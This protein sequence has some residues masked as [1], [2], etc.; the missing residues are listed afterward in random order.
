MK[1]KLATKPNRRGFGT[2]EI[3]IALALMIVVIV[4]AV[5]ANIS[6]QYWSMTSE[7]SNE[8]LYKA[9]TIIEQL[10]ATASKD[11]Q[12]ASSSPLT[13][14]MNPLDGAD[15]ACI[16]GGM[17]YSIKRTVFDISSCS[18]FTEAYV[19]WR[20]GMR[21]PT[22]TESLYTNLTNNNEIIA[23]G[24]DC[25]LNE[26]EGDW[27]S[28]S[29]DT[30]GSLS[31]TPL[32]AYISGIDVLQ[33]RIYLVSS[34]SPQLRVFAVPNTAPGNPSLLG[35][36]GGTGR[37]L[38][39]VDAIR[40]MSTGRTYAFVTQNA[41]TSQLA[42]FDVTDSSLPSFVSERTLSG[43][44]KT[45]DH[46]EGWRL[47]SYG[48]RFFEGGAYKYEQRLY[49][50]T[51][52]TTG[53]ELHIFNI[54]A[55]TQPTEIVSAATSLNRTVNDM[56]VREQMYN[57]TLHRYLFLAEDPGASPYTKHLRV[58]DVTDDSPVEV[59][60]ADL[61]GTADGLS[62]FLTGNRLYLGRESGSGPELYVFDV[63]VLLGGGLI[64]PLA[65]S[66]VGADVTT[67]RGTGSFLYLGTRKSGEEF[68]VWHADASTWSDSVPNAGRISFQDIPRLA[69]LGL[70]VN[71]NWVYAV[72]QSAS[73]SELL[74]VINAP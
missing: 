54:N 58:Y 40:D 21:Y 14:S 49:V 34:T 36:T 45:G 5:N 16:A 64:T 53:P 47:F 42:V 11:F 70:D 8:G 15:T 2:L 68:Q 30:V 74:T 63:Q 19:E 46:P 67:I 24:G 32:G 1:A 20:L 28:G 48:G 10:R 13:V 66:E 4:G 39:S 31:L 50:T 22:T 38:N 6:A 51:R 59:A 37:R 9:K 73:L 33:K 71:I 26:P 3:I 72:S 43:V 12:S 7:T 25:L 57:G 18:K 61:S 17:C 44:D 69:P 60:W 29:L 55:P 65:T 23:L 56:V 35:S 62:L 52:E 27:T 41:S